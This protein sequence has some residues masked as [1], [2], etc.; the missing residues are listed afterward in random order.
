MRLSRLGFQHGVN[1][2]D[3]AL[4]PGEQSI[5]SAAMLQSMPVTGMYRSM[6]KTSSR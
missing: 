2:D 5:N 4:I 1:H 6:T 3:L